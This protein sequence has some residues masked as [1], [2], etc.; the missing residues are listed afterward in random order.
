M[1]RPTRIPAVSSGRIRI[2]LLS[3]AAS[4]LMVQAETAEGLL[5]GWLKS[6]GSLT[7]FEA[8]VVQTRH[9]KALQQPL[10][11]TGR[12]CFVGNGDFR[13][14]LGEPPQSVA[15][16]TGSELLLLSPRLRR[17]EKVDLSKAVPGP[18][19]DLLGLLD[20]GFPRDSRGFR[21]RFELVEAAAPTD[22]ASPALTLKPRSAAARKLLP[23]IRV[24]LDP[25]GLALRAT[26]MTFAD[27]SRLRTEFR[28]VV[29]NRPPDP[30]RFRSPV[31]ATWKVVEGGSRP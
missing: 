17:A 9:L 1:S 23:G 14:E 29:T 24:E 4:V 10:V 19:R 20:V 28:D 13:W 15:L 22:P 11:S 21:E 31:D 3:I 25:T 6:A 26:E 18:A 16:R 7:A 5:D 27:G 12:V 2:R 8:T 30:E